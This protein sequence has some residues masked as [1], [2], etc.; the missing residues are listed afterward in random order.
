M[1]KATLDKIRDVARTVSNNPLER[2]RIEE[3]LLINLV[4]NNSAGNSVKAIAFT[5]IKDINKTQL[6]ILGDKIKW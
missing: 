5:R 1:T 2:L 6:E 3:E 4:R